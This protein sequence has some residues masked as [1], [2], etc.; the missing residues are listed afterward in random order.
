MEQSSGATK[1]HIKHAELRNRN[2]YPLDSHP[3][4][5]KTQKNPMSTIPGTFTPRSWVNECIPNILWACLLTSALDRDHYLRLFRSVAGNI[6]ENIDR[7]SDLF[8]THN[9]LSVFSENEFHIA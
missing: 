8:L 5:G 4:E 2:F 7:H 9:F 6:R 3:R 1:P